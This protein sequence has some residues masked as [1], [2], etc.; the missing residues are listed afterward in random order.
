MTLNK[1]TDEYTELKEKII[2]SAPMS[3]MTINTDGYITFVNEYFKNFANTNQA[4]GRN[5]ANMPFFIREKL[6][7]EFNKLFSTGVPF[8]K[9]NCST[10]T[11]KGETRYINISAVPLK[12]E[13]GRIEGAL[14]MAVDVT[15]T[16]LNKIKLRELNANLEMEVYKKT[17]QLLEANEKLKEAL[18]LKSQFI[19][20]AS[21]EL[22][23]PLAIAKLNLELFKNQFAKKNKGAVKDLDAIDKEINK[24]SEILTDLSLITSIDENSAGKIKND[25]INLDVLIEDVTNRLE[26]MADR[27][28]IDLTWQKNIEV[29]VID[30][31]RSRLETVLSNII[32]NAIKYSPK[33]GWIKIWSEVDSINK[34]I[35]INVSDN[36]IGIPKKDLPHIFDRFYRTDLS[37]KTA[38]GGFGLGL[39][40]CKW[41]IEQHKGSIDVKST[42]GKGTLFAINLPMEQSH[43]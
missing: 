10:K 33:N 15:Q 30:G 5:I 17:S 20:D 27:K 13:N 4:E 39:A 12:D 34:A 19:S 42:L 22:R 18:E 41:I 7:P 32:R 40:I 24:L 2:D 35:I 38:E 21:H 23:T 11:P 36:G 43:T 31:D 6:L 28:N 1:K 8:T 14:S 25:K 26:S 37:R 29:S 9:R 16:I 3:I